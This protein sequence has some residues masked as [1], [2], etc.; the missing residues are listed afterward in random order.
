MKW[1]IFGLLAVSLI[2]TLISC[3]QLSAEIEAYRKNDEGLEALNHG[4]HDDA[5]AYF[6]EAIAS[7][8]LSTPSRAMVYRNIAQ[9][10]MDMQV[11]DSAIHYASLAANCYKP[12]S[13]D[14]LVNMADVHI[15]SD[16]IALAIE[17]LGKAYKMRPGELAVN[18]TLGLIYLGEYDY[19][20]M[21]IENALQYNK[22]AFEINQDRNT[23]HVLAKNY[24]ELE[25]YADA[26]RHFEN[27]YR[28]YPENPEHAVYLGITKHQ[29]GLTAEAAQLW[30]QALAIDSA[31]QWIIMHYQEGNESEPIH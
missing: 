2:A 7:A 24:F 6:Q 16:D 1:T 13:Y 19:A 21:D 14:F 29:L 30:D 26:A 23:E 18:N 27:L 8:S 10:Y 3:S 20:Y 11:P 9:V 22:K 17:A 25:R 5:I 15:L 28:Q 4:R 31:Y 12:G